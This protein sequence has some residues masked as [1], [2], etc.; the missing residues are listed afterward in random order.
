MQCE[1][2]E[3]RLQDLL[4][5][6]L[7]PERDPALVDHAESCEGCRE[8]LALQEQMFS[9]LAMLEVPTLDAAF[10]QRVMKEYREEI[11]TAE[12][13][14][15]PSKRFAFNWKMLTGA[16]AAS[17]LVGALIVAMRN[18][19]VPVPAPVIVQPP[20]KVVP[21]PEKPVDAP[22]VAVTPVET[23]SKVEVP[24]E[25]LPTGEIVQLVESADEI[26]DGRTTGRMIR[27]VTSMQEVPEVEKQ[28]PGFRPL[29][30]GFSST[31]GM[32]R[33][34]LPGGR[35]GQRRTPKASPMTKPQAEFSANEGVELA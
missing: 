23:P 13:A 20:P 25:T 1:K 11:L 12:L 18:N 30:S 4:D 29:A 34:T 7:R 3:S 27:E 14:P 33:K 2:F 9:G 16:L 17:L 31:L 24:F 21:V 22:S 8:M 28:I 26:L 10:S 15:L 32:V 35:D 6:R 19:N 5:Q